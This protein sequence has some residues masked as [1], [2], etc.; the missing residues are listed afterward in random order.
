MNVTTETA[1]VYR[2]GGRRYLTRRAA[3]MKAA[4]RLMQRKCDCT[5]Y[6]KDTGAGGFNCKYCTPQFERH[7]ELRARLARWLQHMD[8][9]MAGVAR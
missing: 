9:R 5:P 6:E 4:Y 2:G 8:S 7:A 3:Y 1:T